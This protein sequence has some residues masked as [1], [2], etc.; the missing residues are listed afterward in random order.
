MIRAKLQILVLAI[1]LGCST[2]NAL[3]PFSTDGC[4]RWPDG[5]LEHRDL[6]LRC[7]TEHDLRYWLGGT[8]VERAEADEALGRCVAAVGEPEMAALMLA[9]VR[10]G[11]SAYWPTP[12]RWGY[13]WSYGRGYRLLTESERDLAER[14]LF[15]VPCETAP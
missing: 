2:G 4:S 15:G 3:R 9:G 12:Y 14:I 10:I 11:G 6:W 13:G 5:T 7:C 8:R 1:V